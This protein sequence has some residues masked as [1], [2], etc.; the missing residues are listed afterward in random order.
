MND[1][2]ETGKRVVNHIIKLVLKKKQ[3]SLFTWVADNAREFFSS[4]QNN[5]LLNESAILKTT[6]RY[7]FISS[8]HIFGPGFTPRIACPN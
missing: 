5:N 2:N 3:V 7:V 1:Y 6:R 4:N 8:A